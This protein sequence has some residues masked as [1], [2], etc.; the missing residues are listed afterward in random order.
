MDAQDFII[1]KIEPEMN[2]TGLLPWLKHITETSLIDIPA[3]S[4]PA[5]LVEDDEP[6]G[7]EGTFGDGGFMSKRG[8]YNMALIVE[9]KQLNTMERAD[10]RTAKREISKY[11]MEIQQF[12]FDAFKADASYTSDDERVTLI[13]LGVNK[14]PLDFVD[15]NGTACLML[16]MRVDA[17]WV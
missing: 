9:T 3:D 16:V 8:T 2:E 6:L 11:A 13:G 1:G 14:G 12:L 4:Y 7:L 15:I 17:K 10:Y 5:L